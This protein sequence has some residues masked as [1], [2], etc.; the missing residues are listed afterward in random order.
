MRTNLTTVV[1]R[2][3]K[4]LDIINCE[5][6]VFT[7]LTITINLPLIEVVRSI[8]SAPSYALDLTLCYSI[9]RRDSHGVDAVK[10]AVTAVTASSCCYRSIV[11]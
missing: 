8:N 3:S 4:K 11:A 6:F 1:L 9:D 5:T 2:I 7:N 10:V